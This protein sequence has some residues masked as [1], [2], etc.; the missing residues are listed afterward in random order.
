MR[1]NAGD[2]TEFRLPSLEYI[3]LVRERE[4]LSLDN[5]CTNVL[6]KHI[7]TVMVNVEGWT[8][9][10]E[11]DEVALARA[12]EAQKP[13]LQVYS[14]LLTQGGYRL[15]EVCFTDGQI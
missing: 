8:T 14:V 1:P 12:G 6:L 2:F 5:I 7:P 3:T 10:G 15:Q 4:V 11:S 9:V 13:C